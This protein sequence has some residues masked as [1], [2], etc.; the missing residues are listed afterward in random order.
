M[1][2]RQLRAGSGGRKTPR[3]PLPWWRKTP[4][5]LHGP[6]N[7]GENARALQ[8]VPSG[9]GHVAE[10]FQVDLGVKV[11]SG[12]WFVGE[13]EQ[14]GGG[15]PVMAVIPVS[16][17]RRTAGAQPGALAPSFINKTKSVARALLANRPDYSCTL[18]AACVLFS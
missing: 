10:F 12:G 4:W 14:G 15:S 3:E 7:G 18:R 9:A 17:A 5:E 8:G 1:F 13:E 16:S 2:I 6:S 11:V